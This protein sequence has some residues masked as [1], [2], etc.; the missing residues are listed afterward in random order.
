[1][2]TPCGFSMCKTVSNGQAFHS[3][4]I[5]SWSNTDDPVSL[6]YHG[7]SLSH[8]TGAG[9]YGQPPLHAANDELRGS[10][11]GMRTTLHGTAVIG[12]F[13][14]SGFWDLSHP[15]TFFSLVTVS[16]AILA[17]LQKH[18]YPTLLD[19]DIPFW[20]IKEVGG[21]EI[22]SSMECWETDIWWQRSIRKRNVLFSLCYLYT[23]NS[24]WHSSCTYRPATLHTQ[25]PSLL[26]HS[27]IQLFFRLDSILFHVWGKG[28]IR[29]LLLSHH[30][31]S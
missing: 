11:R 21:K 25:S 14:S 5:S 6:T 12:N 18:T 4:L 29:L 23:H 30:C 7:T 2:N 16:L 17:S 26:A 28:H 22:Y 1:M 9:S 15:K 27:P 20:E 24:R 19:P 13:T 8:I 31:C 10:A 3:S